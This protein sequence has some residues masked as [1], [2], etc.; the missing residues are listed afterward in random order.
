[1]SLRYFLCLWVPVVALVAG[2]TAGGSRREQPPKSVAPSLSSIN[3]VGDDADVFITSLASASRAEG[4]DA[5][6]LRSWTVYCR[7]DTYFVREFAGDRIGVGFAGVG[8]SNQLA[9][10]SES[11]GKRVV[12]IIQRLSTSPFESE[13][14]FGSNP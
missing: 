7:G 1:M 5:L 13:A 3:V 8:I 10:L 11:N 14:D 9:F 12:N 4:M 2:C 6:A